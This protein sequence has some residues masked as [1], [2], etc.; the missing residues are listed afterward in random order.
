MTVV[1]DNESLNWPSKSARPSSK[2]TYAP[3]QL[4]TQEGSSFFYLIS[5]CRG[6]ARAW[7]DVDPIPDYPAKKTKTPQMGSRTA[8]AGITVIADPCLIEIRIHTYIFCKYTLERRESVR[9][10]FY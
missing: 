10:Q 3:T 6:C 8:G 1:R 5:P 9:G 2:T 4:W 7:M